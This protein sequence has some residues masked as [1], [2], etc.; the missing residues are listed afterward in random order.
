[1]RKNYVLYSALALGM[2][3]S[4]AS[5][6]SDDDFT[7]SG[8]DNGGIVADADQVIEIAVENAGGGL[9]TRNGRPLNSSVAD[10]TIDRLKLIIVDN[11]GDVV[12]DT[13]YENWL[14][15]SETYTEN[16]HGRRVR[17]ELMGCN[18]LAKGGTYTAY[19]IGYHDNTRYQANGEGLDAYLTS[20]GNGSKNNEKVETVDNSA[21]EKVKKFSADLVITNPSANNNADEIF[22]GSAAISMDGNGKFSQG[23]TLHRQ[24][25][26]V[27]SYLTNVPYMATIE[28]GEAIDKADHLQLVAVRKNQTA[29]LGQFYGY[30]LT[31]NGGNS[32]NPNYTPNNKLQNVVNGGN[33]V[34]T[35]T[36]VY[37][38]D[39]NKWFDEIVDNGGE[40]GTGADGIID[41]Y[42]FTK[43]A[44]GLLHEDKAD[45]NWLSPKTNQ[46]ER[47]AGCTF[48]TGSVYGGEFIIPF[49]SA[50]N[51]DKYTFKLRLVSLEAD[52]NVKKNYRE[53]SVSL[54][55]YDILK[56]GAELTWWTGSS[57]T[58]NEKL[59]SDE[60]SSN[61]SVLR[62]HLYGVG[63]RTSNNP[64][65]GT[66][67]DDPTPDVDDPEDLTTKQDLMLQVNDNWELIH[68]MVI[69]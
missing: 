10:Q 49:K 43:G 5:C 23:V 4:F 33:T 40:G 7:M 63:T 35:E 47:F 56:T 41:R 20:V 59:A 34:N 17:F 48:V 9:E 1:M 26:G 52:G 14:A 13:L 62:N 6:S 11:D 44:D 32:G 53:W 12:A 51:A 58:V 21:V 31:D 67:P 29:T 54:P 66:D 16:G 60:S 27:F 8:V 22:A 45:K 42:G 61:Y 46:A 24:V 3:G 28:D 2:M 57:W 19:A 38:I 37:D 50:G 25:A 18:K 64:G 30:A 39:L 68:S 69:E 55:D 65:N 36:V 15:V